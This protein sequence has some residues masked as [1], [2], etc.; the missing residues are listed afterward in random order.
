M[1]S[2]IIAR[3]LVALAALTITTVPACAP[4]ALDEQ[5]SSSDSGEAADAADAADT[6]DGAAGAP[7]FENVARP[8]EVLR[9]VDRA[10]AFS[11]AEAAHLRNAFG[12]AWTGVYIGGPCNGG[13]GWTRQS[14][15][16]IHAATGWQFLPIFVGQQLGIGCAA[17][18]LGFARGRADGDQAAARMRAFGWEGGRDIPVVLDIERPTFDRDRA[19]ATEYARGW[20]DGVHAAGYLGYIYGSFTMLNA[21]AASRLPIDGAWVA[22][23]LSS[24]G[25]GGFLDVS[26]YDPR[27]LLGG[28]FTTRNRAW[29]YHGDVVI[30]GAGRIDTDVSDFLLAP[31]P[32]G[33]NRTGDSCTASET[34]AAAAFGCA[35]VD[36]APSGGFCPGT[37]CSAGETLAAGAFGCACVD[38]VPSGGFCPGTGCTAAETLAAAAFGCACVD[39][40]PSG[41]FCPGS[42]CTAAEEAAARA[43][44]CECVDHVP[45]GGFCPGTGCT[46]A[47]TAAAN[48]IGCDCKNHRPSGGFCPTI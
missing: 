6:A 45:S 16:A 26:P 33:T 35:C 28:N 24:P 23:F 14:V 17:Q 34:A 32:G 5:P 48:S 38:H 3:A 20:L 9:G 27:A 1:T 37:G 12:V 11:P 22:V 41:G 21:F 18:T 46:A 39:H 40:A 29:Q 2:Q 8:V 31:E 36:H 13:F 43:V 42:G 7:D 44:G 47:E 4:G 30:P 10:G 15:E 25:T 19:G